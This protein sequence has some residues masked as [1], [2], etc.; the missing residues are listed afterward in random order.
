MRELNQ[1][2]FSA[3]QSFQLVVT[4]LRYLRDYERDAKPETLNRATDEL[5]RGMRMFPADVA[6]KFYLGV[7]KAISGAAGAREAIS[8]LSEVDQLNLKPIRLLVKYN[9]A[10]ATIETCDES[11]YGG[12]RELLELVER[13]APDYPTASNRALQLQAQVLLMY[14]DIRRLRPERLKI[15]AM[16]LQERAESAPAIDK[17]KTDVMDFRSCL[18]KFGEEFDRENVTE[19]ERAG[20]LAD[21]WNNKGILEWYLAIAETPGEF[22]SR[23]HG[24]KALACF[25]KSL[26]HRHGWPPPRS[27]IA[28]VYEEILGDDARAREIWLGI[29]KTEPSHAF[30][31]ERLG[32]LAMKRSET[33]RDADKQIKAWDEAAKWFRESGGRGAT[34]KLANV[35]LEKLN[36]P[37]EATDTLQTLL[38]R[39]DPADEV[40]KRMLPT[41]YFRLG[42]AE[43]RLGDESAAVSAYLK[44]G[45]PTA[46]DALR[47]LKGAAT[48]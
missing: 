44:S 42:V 38:G 47:R 13:E 1:L 18:E 25:E 33:I 2:Q 32:D 7:A 28:M 5:A 8:L 24:M 35:L 4:G 17:F 43:E 12:A 41:V 23:T 9:L 10:A 27:N 21:F 3:P 22:T 11:R 26:Q 31:K 37:G 6:P 16:S 40:A 19:Q 39:L 20:I 45:L 46:T 30:A 36:S 14:M 48:P 29:L 15:G 34:L